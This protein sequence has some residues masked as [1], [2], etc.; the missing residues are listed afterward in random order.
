MGEEEGGGVGEETER[1]GAKWMIE[2]YDRNGKPIDMERWT[3]LFED[4]EYRR[5]AETHIR[6]VWVS[7]VWL[8]LDH[9]WLPHNRPL[10]FETMVFGGDMDGEMGRCGSESEARVMHEEFVKL[11]KERLDASIE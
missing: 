3:K 5:I 2:W 7:T 1:F 6:D 11:V 10:I 9:A 4:F 8:G